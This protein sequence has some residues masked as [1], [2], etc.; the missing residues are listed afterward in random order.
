M[1]LKG[2]KP[3]NHRM[4]PPSNGLRAP[5]F[6]NAEKRL[7]GPERY[8]IGDNRLGEALEGERA[9]LFGCDAAL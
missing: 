2:K 7:D 5:P 6:N 9:K 8:V 4:T 1:I 3:S